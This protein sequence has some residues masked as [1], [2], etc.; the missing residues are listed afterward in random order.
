VSAPLPGADVERLAADVAA[1]VAVLRGPVVASHETAAALHGLPLLRSRGDRVVVTRAAG[2]GSTRRLARLTVQVA[3]L[4]E[5]EMSTCQ[6]V[7]VTTPSRTVIDLARRLPLREGLVAAD[8]ALARALTGHP[9]LHAVLRRCASWP[10]IRRASR[11][12]A[13]ADG[14]AESPLETLAR[15][16]FVEQGLPAP[17][18][19]AW[20]VDEDDGWSARVDFLWPEERTIGEADGLTKYADM[21]ALRAEKL[22]QERLEQLG[23]VVVRMTWAQVVREPGHTAARIRAAFERGRRLAAGS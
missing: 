17:Q 6:G 9:E 20:V 11:V 19:Q 5:S 14:R 2:C 4:E 10:G 23:F 1:A 21:D 22:R 8:A 13:L 16:S 15:L 12:V 7:P 3:G 18:P